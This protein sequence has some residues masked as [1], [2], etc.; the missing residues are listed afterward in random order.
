MRI[1]PHGLIV[2]ALFCVLLALALSSSASW[3]H[4]AEAIVSILIVLNLGGFF[5]RRPRTH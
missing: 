4:V 3:V 5:L 2:F 1:Y